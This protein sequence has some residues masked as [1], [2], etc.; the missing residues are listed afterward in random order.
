MSIN[1]TNITNQPT[2]EIPTYAPT[3]DPL[4]TNVINVT[5]Q[6]TYAPTQNPTFSPTITNNTSTPT[7][8]TLDTIDNI[9]II[10]SVFLNIAFLVA[11][12]HLFKSRHEFSK[13]VCVQS[14]MDIDDDEIEVGLNGHG[15]NGNYELSLS[16]TN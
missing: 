4:F 3:Q 16:K 15:Q 11:V 1:V 13:K 7:F 12:Y 10:L 5:N 6:P 2:T 8:K 9:F 14:S